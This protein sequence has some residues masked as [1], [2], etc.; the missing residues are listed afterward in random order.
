MI[1]DKEYAERCYQCRAQAFVYLGQYKQ[2]NLDFNELIRLDPKNP[3][4]YYHR[5]YTDGKLG[6]RKQQ[7]ADDTT[8]IR[9]IPKFKSAYLDRA[10][11]YYRLG[12]Y[13]LA[14]RDRRLAK[15]GN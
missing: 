7:V 10:Y 3:W 8:A 5:A 2:A 13:D 12:N 15:D 14:K 1:L 9:L 11:A 4:N 6:Q